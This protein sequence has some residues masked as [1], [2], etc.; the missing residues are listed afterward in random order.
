MYVV[1]HERD[2]QGLTRHDL[3]SAKWDE[4]KLSPS[5]DPVEKAS[6]QTAG[7]TEEQLHAA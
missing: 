2:S 5:A 1:F 3:R 6:V 7:K 4:Y